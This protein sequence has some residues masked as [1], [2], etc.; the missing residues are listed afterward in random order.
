MP[1]YDFERTDRALLRNAREAIGSG[2]RVE[3][4]AARGRQGGVELAVEDDGPGI[5]EGALSGLF[6]PFHTTTAAGTGIGLA[7]CRKIAVEHGGEI[8]AGSSAL[9]GARFALELPAAAERAPPP[10]SPG[11]VRTGA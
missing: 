4:R 2:G 6:K 7:L 1:G 3:L 8:T 9:G 11:R 5:S 10:A